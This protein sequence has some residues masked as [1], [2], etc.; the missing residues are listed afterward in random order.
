MTCL[1]EQTRE[2]ACSLITSRN[3]SQEQRLNDQ[4]TKAHSQCSQY[5]LA[6]VSR[7]GNV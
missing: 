5:A 6:T 4:G 7:T 1:G 3:L 2:Q